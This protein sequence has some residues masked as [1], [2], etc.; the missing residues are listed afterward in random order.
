MLGFLEALGMV[1]CIIE[2]RRGRALYALPRWNSLQIVVYYSE[3]AQGA[4]FPGSCLS[5]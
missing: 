5:E 3:M 4:S 2:L 1:D